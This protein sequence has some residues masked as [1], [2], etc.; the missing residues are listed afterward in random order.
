MQKK[1]GTQWRVEWVDLAGEVRQRTSRSVTDAEQ[2]V[3]QL[4][5]DT[6]EPDNRILEIRTMPIYL[7]EE[8]G[9]ARIRYTNPKHRT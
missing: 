7:F 3:D 5:L 8:T 2:F 1:L 4:L 6:E 9:L